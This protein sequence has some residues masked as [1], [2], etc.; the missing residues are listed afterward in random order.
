MSIGFTLQI[1]FLQVFLRSFYLEAEVI[2]LSECLSDVPESVYSS[3]GQILE[4]EIIVLFFK[5]L[6]VEL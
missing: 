1:Q 3:E 2:K 5:V 6:C 4:S